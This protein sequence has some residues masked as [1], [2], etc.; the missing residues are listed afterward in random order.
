MGKIPKPITADNNIVMTYVLGLET[1]VFLIFNDRP[2]CWMI[3]P[4]SFEARKSDKKILT[5][6]IFS[7]SN[8][9]GTLLLP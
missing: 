4:I 6:L 3:K 9:V 1:T 7:H 8:T 2:I 5:F